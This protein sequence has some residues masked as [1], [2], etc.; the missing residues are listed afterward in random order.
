MWRFSIYFISFFIGIAGQVEAAS[1]Y[2]DPTSTEVG[3]GGLVTMGVRLQT[4]P[5]ECINAID[6]VIEFD[7]GLEVADV[8]TG[9][10]IFNLWVEP[11]T[12]DN[13]KKRVTFAGGVSNGYCGRVQGDPQLTNVVAEIIFRADPGY[14]ENDVYLVQFSELTKGYLNDGFGTP[15]AVALDTAEVSVNREYIDGEDDEWL[16]R[17]EADVDAPK[18]FSITLTQ[19][20]SAFAGKYFITFN[21][22]D[23]QTGISHYEVIEEPIEDINVFGWGAA[24][25]PWIRATS[26][27][28]LQ[29]QSL[30]S[31]IRV[32]AVDK[33]GNEY[34]ATLV[35]D[36][37]VRGLNRPMVVLY[38]VTL[39]AATSLIVALLFIVHAFTLRRHDEYEEVFES[40]DEKN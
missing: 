21:T 39:L 10:S 11:P 5:D 9:N 31:I 27:Y 14:E 29:D 38:G 3:H 22:N 26:P 15:V 17:V 30:N 16:R 33:A 19:D 36:E 32:K 24:T 6:A 8:S 35:P 28:R 40:N 7:E 12:F 23:K 4:T 2:F 18:E 37:S 20:D 34:I 13:A 1:L 25:A